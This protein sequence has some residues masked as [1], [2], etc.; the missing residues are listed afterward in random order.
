MNKTY[1][2]NRF[3]LPWSAGGARQE[4]NGNEIA[5]HGAHEQVSVEWGEKEEEEEGFY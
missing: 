3:M 2:C 5:P 4:C 1:E